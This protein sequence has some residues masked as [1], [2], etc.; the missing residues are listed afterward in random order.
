M[1]FLLKQPLDPA[2]T[3]T[4]RNRAPPIRMTVVRNENERFGL[5]LRR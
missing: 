1:F 3:E 2:D 4:G 5:W